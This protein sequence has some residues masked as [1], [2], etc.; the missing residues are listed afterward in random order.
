MKAFFLGQTIWMRLD[1]FS[2]C[3][4]FQKFCDD[5][6]MVSLRYHVIQLYDALM[7]GQINPAQLG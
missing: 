2:K 1:I 7:A 4:S 3:A 6:D 5:V